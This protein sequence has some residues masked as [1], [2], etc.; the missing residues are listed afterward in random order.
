MAEKL[1]AIVLADSRDFAISF[2]PF[3]ILFGRK[4]RPIKRRFMLDR[5]II[6][7][8][9]REDFKISIAVFHSYI[10]LAFNYSIDPTTHLNV[11][12]KGSDSNTHEQKRN[13]SFKN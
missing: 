5:L 11:H 1:S 3:Y 2:L 9:E 4:N 7:V 13:C 8:T 12:S 6:L 10:C